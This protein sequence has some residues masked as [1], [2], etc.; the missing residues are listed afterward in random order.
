[1]SFSVIFINNMD[2]LFSFCTKFL[3]FRKY[4]ICNTFYIMYLAGGKR[5]E[6]LVLPANSSVSVTLDLNEVG[7]YFPEHI[8][9]IIM[10][11]FDCTHKCFLENK[12]A[13]YAIV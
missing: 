7:P 3:S 6:N 10:I 12:E 1:M 13:L 2:H 11:S 5:D 9:Y 8:H 4:F